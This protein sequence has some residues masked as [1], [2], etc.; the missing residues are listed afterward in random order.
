MEELQQMRLM[1]L[2]EAQAKADEALGHE[3][4]WPRPDLSGRFM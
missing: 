1:T 4:V 2:D 3:I